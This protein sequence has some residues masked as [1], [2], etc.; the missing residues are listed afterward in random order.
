M[1]FELLRLLRRYIN[2]SDGSM[3]P[4]I[5]IKRGSLFS[6]VCRTFPSRAL[7]LVG[8]FAFS[9]R[10][11]RAKRTVFADAHRN[12][13]ADSRRHEEWRRVKFNNNARAINFDALSRAF[14][15][16]ARARDGI[17]RRAT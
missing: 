9:T 4:S 6:A 7:R 5:I 1:P 17:N 13:A 11:F 10:R 16:D 12:Y 2:I 8:E 15:G 3:E 14:K